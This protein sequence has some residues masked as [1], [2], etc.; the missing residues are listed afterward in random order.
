MDNYNALLTFFR[1][2]SEYANNSFFI[3]C[4]FKQPPRANERNQLPPRAHGDLLIFCARFLTPPTPP[5]P[6]PT[7][8][9]F[10]R[11]E[12]Y[13][14][15]YVPTLAQQVVLGNDAGNPRVNLQGIAVGNGCLGLD[16]GV[17]AFDFRNELN[18]NM[19]F[20]SGHGLISPVTYAAVQKDCDPSAA[21]PSPS[22]QSDFDLAHS[23]I[24]NVNIYDIYGDCVYG[25][26]G[27]RKD[28]S[29][30]AVYSKAPV[31]MR[32]GS[33]GPVECIDETIAKY[34]GR[35]DVATALNVIPGLHWA[36]C[37]S[38]SSFNY[39]R[40]ERDERVD[41]YP[42]IWKAGVY[43]LHASR[44]PP[45]IAPEKRATNKNTLTSSPKTP[46]CPAQPRFDLQRRALHYTLWSR[47]RNALSAL[48]PLPPTTGLNRTMKVGLAP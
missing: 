26:T 25:A 13:A 45:P 8:I 10:C 35:A 36:V 4:V 33:S 11:G 22:C 48:N 41:V 42:T 28:A 16:I 29:G 32:A 27:G 30:N 24:G 39:Q 5:M 31:P 40:T 46:L 43:V 17:C 7:P 9:S 14:G 15:I 23:E 2:F 47:A 18:T 21:G 44:S 34:I 3:T 38:N 6:P 37:G 19:P 12:S 20:F 1:G